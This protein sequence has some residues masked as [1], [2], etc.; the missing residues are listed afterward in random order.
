MCPTAHLSR[1]GENL[2]ES[3]LSFHH[4][5]PECQAQVI[6]LGGAHL[7]LMSHLTSSVV[8]VFN[9]GFCS[10]EFMPGLASLLLLQHL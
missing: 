4:V 3:V 1:A 8:F 9:D 10:F 5:G 6:S 2:Q 7:S